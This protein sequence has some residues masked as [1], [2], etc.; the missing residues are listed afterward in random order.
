MIV[1]QLLIWFVNSNV[2]NAFSTGVVGFVSGPLF[3]GTLGMA[4]DVLPPDV[5]LVSMAIM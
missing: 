2:A 1:M 4:S 5:H 3:P